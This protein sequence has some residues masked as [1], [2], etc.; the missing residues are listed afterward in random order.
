MPGLTITGL[1]VRAGDRELLSDTSFEIP[2]GRLTVLVGGSGAGKS[3]LLRILAGLLPRSGPAIDWTGDFAS[4]GGENRRLRVGVVFQQFA[5]FDEWSSASNVGFAI[6]HRGDR[7]DPPRLSVAQWLG[8]MKLPGGVPVA[9]LS[10]GQ[11]QRLAIARTLAADPDVLLYDE[12]TSGLDPVTGASVAELIRQT[13]TRFGTTSVVVT[14]DIETLLPIADRVLLLDARAGRV[15]EIPPADWP[16]L[17]DRLRDAAPIINDAVHQK[18]K[19]VVSVVSALDRAVQTTGA[20]LIATVSLPI[21]AWPT[22]VR[23]RWWLRFAGHYFRLVAGPSAVVYLIVAGLIAGFTTTYFT[24]RFLPFRVYTQPLLIDDLLASIGFALY[25]VLVPI[26]ATILIAARCGAAVAAD[27]GV[28]RYNGQTDALRTLGST[29]GGYLLLPI[30]VVFLVATPLLEFI[31]LSAAAAISRVTF[32]LSHPDIGGWFWSQHFWRAVPPI[33]DGPG[34]WLP[35]AWVP[36]VGLGWVLGKSVACGLGTAAISYH[37]GIGPKQSAAD[38]SSAVTA[39]VL[40]S[41]LWV[42]AVHFVAALLEF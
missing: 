39:T 14:H 29:P 18:G 16:S 33:G 15:V 6:S 27:V 35:L 11:K 34:G 31:A 2:D 19:G 21:T 3:V 17:T 42:L 10:G 40:W 12:P 26:L 36:R 24:L 7:S 32:V 5:L 25:R 22:G 13:Q 9:G 38:V 1:S 8:A 30:L 23:P 4:I 41:T 28:K 37:L 20:A